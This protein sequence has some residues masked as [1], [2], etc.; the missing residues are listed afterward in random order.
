MLPHSVGDSTRTCQ[1]IGVWS[2]S[3]PTC[4]GTVVK[5]DFILSIC[6][7]KQVTTIFIWVWTGSAPTCEGLLLQ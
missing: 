3:A 1:A 2:G 6:A 4:E 5:G 7:Y